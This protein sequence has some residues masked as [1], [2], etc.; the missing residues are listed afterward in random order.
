MARVALAGLTAIAWLLGGPPA[1]SLHDIVRRMGTYVDSYGDRASIVV[2]TERYS[3][4]AVNPE[5]QASAH[6]EAD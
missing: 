6:R 3:Q 1:P 2:A 5:T 4:I